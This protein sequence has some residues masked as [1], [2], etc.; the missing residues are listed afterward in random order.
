MQRKVFHFPAT[1]GAAA[2][3]VCQKGFF[4]AAIPGIYT[5]KG[6]ILE[7][8]IDRVLAQ[9][10]DMIYKIALTRVKNREDAEDILQDVLVRYMVNEKP[11]E[12]E[13][14]EKAWLIR[15][16]INCCNK[17]VTTS[18]AKRVT[19]MDDLSTLTDG[20]LGGLETKAENEVYQAVMN[21]PVKYRDPIHL[22][23]YEELSVAEIAA[24][25]GMKENTVKSLLLR[26]RKKLKDML[27][28]DYL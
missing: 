11:F 22:F 21:L 13:E 2:G 27:G 8:G 26:G 4:P 28:P 3:Y 6:E 12:S 23:Y 1:N 19:T 24:A 16:T 9:Y 20:A 18:W 14:H 7:S 25:L 17:Q 15:V 10:S 5:Q